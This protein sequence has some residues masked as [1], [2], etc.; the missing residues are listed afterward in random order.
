MSPAQAQAVTETLYARLLEDREIAGFFHHTDL[1]GQMR[2]MAEAL[3]D[4]A[5]YRDP[6]AWGR[7][8]DAH[9][10]LLGQGLHLGHFDRVV[11][12]LGQALEAASVQDDGPRL[13]EAFGPLRDAIFRP[14]GSA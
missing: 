3:A 4:P 9:R 1:E 7:L 2:K 14:A 6:A 12:A 8:V 10:A 13:I 5:R 11:S